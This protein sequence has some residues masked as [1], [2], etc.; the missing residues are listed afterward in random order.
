M[1][2][3]VLALIK[4]EGWKRTK[5]G[6]IVYD[7][8]YQ[9]THPA[10]I[11][12]DLYRTQKNPEL[13]YQH[14]KAAHDYF[15]P[16]DL[17]TWHYWTERR[18]R[19]H[20]KG[21]N[22]MGWAGG[23]STAKSYDAAKIALIFW[24]CNPR[25]RGLVIASTTL[26]S[27]GARVWGYT[28]KLLSSMAVKM[29]FQ[30]LG[31]NSPKILY[32]ASKEDQEIRDTVHGVFA[33]AAKQ[34]SDESAISSWIGRHPE[35]A[36]MLILDEATDLNPAI[37]KAL[38]N[39]DSS[40]K[41]FQLIGIGNS[42]SKH[43]LH[44][45]LC[46][47]LEGWNS[48]DPLKDTQWKTTQKNGV[49]LFFNCY[50]SP[51]IHEPDPVKRKAL[52]PF[53]IT[54]EQ[55]EE[56]EKLLG[57]DSEAFYR[58]VLGFWKGG[59]SDSTI[60]SKEF[61]SAFDIHSKAEWLGAESIKVVAGLDAAFSTGGDGCILRL[62]YLGQTINGDMVLDF[63]GD[64]LLYK[65]QIRARSDKS[66]EIQIAEQ[67]VSLLNQHGCPLHHLAID[68]SGQ[69]RALGGTL[70][71]QAKALRPPIKI[72]NTR[73]GSGVDKSF[74][75]VP[76]TRHELWFDFRKFVEQGQIKGLD[77]VAAAQF[78]TRLIVQ[79][80]KTGKQELELKSDYKKRMA[81]I[82]PSLAHSPDEADAATLCLQAAMI[83]FGFFPGQKKALPNMIADDFQKIAAWK[84]VNRMKQQ[85]HFEGDVP[86]IPVATFVGDLGASWKQSPIK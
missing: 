70:Y 49:C 37:S 35:D 63:R 25:K 26:E 27:L 32:P 1:T 60:L 5:T 80:A 43:D 6:V 68:A 36:L 24:L 50:E 28:T 66:A 12:L 85:A 52:A 20:C 59:G 14:M 8:E 15:W 44:G 75:V 7:Q 83:N 58:F 21:W 10:L 54:K 72:Y 13:R 46:T 4:E 61:M 74:D 77:H 69:G 84:S 53:L 47:P 62:G 48:I 39:L 65:I 71:L 2:H 23:A 78:V 81:A 38:P 51:A 42:N 22:Y 86:E 76:R 33:V 73:T 34:G 19:E 29:P 16:K 17:K 67:V 64:K 18:F 82:M 57:K 31:G 56:K 30:Y 45:A 3:D 55:V 9:L 41:P 11:H 79:N 40:E